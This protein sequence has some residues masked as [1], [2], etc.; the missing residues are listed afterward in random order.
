VLNQGAGEHPLTFCYQ[1]N[2]SCPRT[3]HPL[4]IRLTIYLA[5]AAGI[6]ITVLGNLFVVFT[7]SYFK[8]LH[9]PT[10]F[11]LLFLALADMLL[12]L[13][14]L[15]LSTIR[16]VGWRESC[17]YFGPSFCSCHTCC[18][19][20]FCYSSL[21]HLCFISTDR[22]IAVTDLLAFPLK[23]TAS[24]SGICIGLSWI[25]PTAYSG[26][27]FSTGANGEG[28]EDLS[29]ALNCIRGCQT[30][31][32]QNWVLINFLSFFIPTLVMIILY[33][34]IFL[35]AR[36][37]AKKMEN[38]AGQTDAASADTYKSRVAKRERKAAKTPSI[39]VLEFTISWLRY[40]IDSLIDVFLGFITPYIY[41][42]CCWCAYYNSA[43]NPLIYALFYPKFRKAITFIVS[44][45]LFKDSSATMNLFSEQN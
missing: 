10:N 22:D 9:T 17:W 20:A 7:V 42:I 34:N 37:Q 26:A 6:I 13:L 38:T 44:G 4:G 21:F 8:A 36:Q 30:A 35:G 16:S 45:G 31:V 41:G 19:V 11:L 27:M 15:P 5:C 25:L 28:L 29:C 39:T 2:G 3:V 40:S 32:N 43:T 24:V 23:F 18:C 14:V 12:G 33:S 1:V